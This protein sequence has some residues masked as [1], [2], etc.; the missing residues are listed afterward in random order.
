MNKLNLSPGA[1]MILSLLNLSQKP[2]D[3]LSETEQELLNNFLFDLSIPQDVQDELTSSGAVEIV[4]NQLTITKLGIRWVLSSCSFGQNFDNL[5][6]GLSINALF[7]LFFAV[8]KNLKARS[9]PV[10]KLASKTG[11]PSMLNEG[12][13]DAILYLENSVEWPEAQ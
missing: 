4:E 12:I 5:V 6:K 9:L 10:I 1:F 13:R 2:A 7:S 3:K 11:E 8:I